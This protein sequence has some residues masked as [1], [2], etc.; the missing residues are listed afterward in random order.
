M[1]A[2]RR[3]RRATQLL[4]IEAVGAALRRVAARPAGHP[5]AP[6]SRS[7][8]RSRACIAVACGPLPP[9]A[10]ARRPQPGR[11]CR[12]RTRHSLLREKRNRHHRSLHRLPLDDLEAEIER[13]RPDDLGRGRLR[14]QHL[15]DQPPGL[16]ADATA[17]RPGWWSGSARRRGR[18]RSPE[19]HDRQVVRHADPAALAF[20]DGADRAEIGDG[21]DCGHRPRALQQ[22]AHG[23]GPLRERERG[24]ALPGDEI[25][26]KASLA[27]AWRR[28]HRDAASPDGRRL[29]HH[30]PGRLPRSADGPARSDTW[31][32]PG[33]PPGWRSRPRGRSAGPGAPRSPRSGYPRP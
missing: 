7:H 18:S 19:A 2:G 32:R 27:A 25:G 8:C 10:L 28:S 6:P 21:K 15:E 24:D 23:V 5:A 29:A 9:P 3:E 33:R 12:P 4:G 31:P 13:C 14:T 16:E 26:G 1:R 30:R 22:L 17:R 20:G 11:P